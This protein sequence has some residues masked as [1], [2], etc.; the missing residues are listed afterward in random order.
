VTTDLFDESE[1]DTDDSDF[2]WD[3]FVPDP[4]EAEETGF[5]AD[6]DVEVDDSDFAWDKLEEDSEPDEK[7]AG[8]VAH[9]RAEA[10]LDRIFDSVRRSLDAEPE[11]VPE[12][13]LQ[14]DPELDAELAAESSL[15]VESEAGES[16]HAEVVAEAEP[17]AEPAT[18]LDEEAE[19]EAGLVVSTAALHQEAEP[20]A[21]PLAE[22]AELEPDVEPA[23]AASR[24]PLHARARRSRTRERPSR[25]FIA[26]AVIACV[27][28]VLVSAD[29]IRHSLHHA[30]AATAAGTSNSAAK[31]ASSARGASRIQS[32]TDEVDSATTAARAGLASL[33]GFPTTTNVA[34]VIN[35][36]LASLRLYETLMSGTT[37]PL[38]A[39]SAAGV[40]RGQVR[41][42]VSFMG[43]IDGLPP[44]RLGA[45]LGEFITDTTQ[46]QTT[47]GTLEQD[48][49][50]P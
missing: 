5:A 46:L 33:S 3:E 28:L 30:P 36:Y 26:T 13:D 41:H 22:H 17:D 15:M 48:L 35:P 45:F 42:D 38:P 40:A 47:L 7:G 2:A 1:L 9:V 6:D 4:D 25:V 16:G 29:A 21:A 20:E 43:T 24:G 44:I 12:H 49:R 14:H 10:A 32:A 11:T 50:T 23:R 8:A 31:A 19:P 34:T 27:F 18:D 39:R 37:V